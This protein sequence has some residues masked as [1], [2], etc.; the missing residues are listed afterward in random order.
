MYEKTKFYKD[1]IPSRYFPFNKPLFFTER[2]VWTI[3]FN[4]DIFFYSLV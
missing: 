2:A 3:L 1:D 4:S